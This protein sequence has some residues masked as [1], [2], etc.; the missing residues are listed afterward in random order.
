MFRWA[1]STVACRVAWARPH[2]TEECGLLRLIADPA[3]GIFFRN[4]ARFGALLAKSREMKSKAA[5]FTSFEVRNVR[6]A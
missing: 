4:Q 3:G 5:S 6:R 2:S 1:R